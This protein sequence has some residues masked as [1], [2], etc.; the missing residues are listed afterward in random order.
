MGILSYFGKQ[1]Y[2]LYIGYHSGLFVDQDDQELR[3]RLDYKY[4][5]MHENRYKGFGVDFDDLP[6]LLDPPIRTVIS[7][8]SDLLALSHI[9]DEFNEAQANDLYYRVSKKIEKGNISYSNSDHPFPIK[10]RFDYNILGY[11][12]DDEGSKWDEWYWDGY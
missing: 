5:D 7:T 1:T 10:F 6:R 11:P 3:F 8:S 4:M 9:A 12:D 2:T